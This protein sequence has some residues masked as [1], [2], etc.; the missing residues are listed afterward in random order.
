MSLLLYVTINPLF[1]CKL[2]AF[3]LGALDAGGILTVD[4]RGVCRRVHS[5][6]LTV[7]ARGVCRRVHSHKLGGALGRVRTLKCEN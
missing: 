2:E 7:D 3:F 4:A 6:I 5:R 1:L